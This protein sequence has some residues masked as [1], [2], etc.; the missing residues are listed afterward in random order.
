MAVMGPRRPGCCL[1]SQ[2]QKL[3]RENW[4]PRVGSRGEAGTF[5]DLVSLARC[6]FARGEV[7]GRFP[8]ASNNR[9]G[10]MPGATDKICLVKQILIL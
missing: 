6:D 8:H 1:G 10:P 5:L 4:F 9:Q 7:S 2:W 3:R